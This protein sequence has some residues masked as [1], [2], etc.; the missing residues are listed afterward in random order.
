MN[1]GT[2]SHLAGIEHLNDMNRAATNARR[3]AAAA[4]RPERQPR[5]PEPRLSLTSLRRSIRVA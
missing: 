5:R 1:P 4:P 3:T 2:I